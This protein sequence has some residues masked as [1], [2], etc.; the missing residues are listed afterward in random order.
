MQACTCCCGRATGEGGFCQVVYDGRRAAQQQQQQQHLQH[1]R[2]P[3][4]G[5]NG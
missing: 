5:S 3:A 2:Q 4:G 1:K